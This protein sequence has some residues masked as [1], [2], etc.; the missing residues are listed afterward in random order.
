ME[1]VFSHTPLG[2]GPE[3][4]FFSHV[5]SGFIAYT[6]CCFLCCT[7]SAKTTRS[8]SQSRAVNSE[9]IVR[10]Q[11]KSAGLI[12]T[13]LAVHKVAAQWW[14]TCVIRQLEDHRSLPMIPGLG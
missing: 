8:K 6:V 4:L 2:P 9:R 14:S 5:L 1:N 7:M 12:V 10:A 3:G 11:R 13:V